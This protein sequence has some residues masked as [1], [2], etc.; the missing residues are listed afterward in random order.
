MQR[1]TTSLH[2]HDSKQK[3]TARRCFER[4]VSFHIHCIVIAD[5]A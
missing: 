5:A 1:E 3:E 2:F 4:A